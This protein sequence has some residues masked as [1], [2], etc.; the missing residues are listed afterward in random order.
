MISISPQTLE[1][2]SQLFK[3][4]GYKVRFEKGNFRSASCKLLDSE[5][6]VINRF[7]DLETKINALAELFN[8][9]N[10]DCS[11]LD[12]KQKK[13]ATAVKQTKRIL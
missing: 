7:S 11:G 5:I 3:A 2:L 10:L 13:F 8:D 12:D 6:I 9:L 4:F 1:K